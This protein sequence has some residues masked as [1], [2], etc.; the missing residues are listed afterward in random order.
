MTQLDKA[1]FGDRSRLALSERRCAL[2]Q[3]RKECRCGQERKTRYLKSYCVYARLYYCGSDN[4]HLA[5]QSRSWCELLQ[6]CVLLQTRPVQRRATPQAVH[7]PAKR[8]AQHPSGPHARQ[9]QGRKGLEGLPSIG[10]SAACTSDWRGLG[11]HA[12][13]AQGRQEYSRGLEHSGLH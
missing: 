6:G 7:K 10:Y 13:H 1:I 4:K 3:S 11:L 12:S 8:A 2:P 5:W 9:H